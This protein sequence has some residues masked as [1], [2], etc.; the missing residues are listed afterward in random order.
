MALSNHERIGKGLEVRDLSYRL[1][2][3]CER[4]KWA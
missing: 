1:Y 2:I 4:R 3:N